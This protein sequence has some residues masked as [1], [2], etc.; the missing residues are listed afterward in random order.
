M[1]SLQQSGPERWESLSGCYPERKVGVTGYTSPMLTFLR[2]II[3][4]SWLNR[5]VRLPA[6]C[7]VLFAL[8]LLLSSSPQ[9][10]DRI[11]TAIHGHDH[12]IV[13]WELRNFFDKWLSRIDSIF[14]DE[15]SEQGAIAEVREYARLTGEI[16]RMEG[17]INRA[18]SLG[19]PVE[20]LEV[21]RSD[22]HQQRLA[23]ESR[24]EEL[25]EGQVSG[26]LAEA[27]M[28]WSVGFLDADGYLFPPVDFKYE[29]SP[30]VLVISP[31]DR[32]ELESTRLL[33]PGLG[34]GARE[35][36]EEDIEKLDED[37]SAL[38][39]N[40]GG[41]ATFPAVVG[42]SSNLQ[43]TL[44]T[45]AHEWFHHYLV[46]YPLGRNYWASGEM[47]TINETVA[48]IAGNEV[49]DA[50]YERYYQEG[51]PEPP[52]PTHG[53][54]ASPTPTP[55]PPSFS[56]NSAMRETRLEADRLLAEGRIEEAEA[57]MEERRLVLADNGYFL[58]KLNQAYF[59]FHGSYADRPTA[60]SP[61]G[62]Q[63]RQIRDRSGTLKEFIE[64]MSRVSSHEDLL[65]LVDG[66]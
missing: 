15:L 10:R 65:R 57:Y 12:D 54:E 59:A 46:F 25:I 7:L 40:T 62:G 32:I 26:I 6:L 56:F 20:D 18:I 49:G 14:D 43:Y 35:D 47:V 30:P 58:R 22:M 63:V 60:V 1:V 51:L 41:V 64:T 34:V 24:V 61:I 19:E 39:I 38:V 5:R 8:V 13:A 37:Y 17:Q 27:G 36:I 48:N 44:R 55:E 50:A 16:N 23:I 45:V 11:G 9:T 66:E 31:R 29:N 53:P 21:E 42:A 28:S 4:L 33:T 52:A 3:D 2:E